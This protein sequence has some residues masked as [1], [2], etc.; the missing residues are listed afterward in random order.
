MEYQQHLKKDKKIATLLF[1]AN[2][3]IQK[4]KNTPVRL[5]ASIISQQLS[6][7]VAAII[8]GRFIALFDG[9]E[10]SCAQVLQ[11]TNDQLR[12]IGL[13]Q[14]KV[15]YIQNVAQF[16]LTHKISDKQ[17]YSMEPAAI[18]ELLTQIKGVGK[19]TVEMLMLFSLGQEDVFAVDDLGIQQAMIRLYKI[20]YTTKKELHT[21]MLSISNQWAPYRSYACLHLWQWKDQGAV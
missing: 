14:S 12:S 1:E 6:T 18:V 7:K 11:C 8:F 21:K 10:P 13:S 4:R 2:H 20:E 5:M 9:K 16:F 19:W 3:V 15:N 17:L